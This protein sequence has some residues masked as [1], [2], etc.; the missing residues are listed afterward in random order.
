M[1]SISSEQLI[2]LEGL[3]KEIEKKRE[4][5]KDKDN[6]LNAAFDSTLKFAEENDP[7]FDLGK[8][9]VTR[10]AVYKRLQEDRQKHLLMLKELHALEL[11]TINLMY[12]LAKAHE[13]IATHNLEVETK[14]AEQYTDKSISVP[15][16]DDLKKE[17]KFHLG[18]SSAKNKLKKIMSSNKVFRFIGSKRMCRKTKSDVF[19]PV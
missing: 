14:T 2:P 6:Q 3:K 16:A 18:V 10:I 17:L 8:G 11:E 9:I 5:I 13:I 7:N 15:T 1:A 12:T 19:G 4:L